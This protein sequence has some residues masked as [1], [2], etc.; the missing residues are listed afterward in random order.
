M[1]KLIIGL[2]TL[3]LS[4][5]AAMAYSGPRWAKSTLNVSIQKDEENPWKSVCIKNAFN[6]W[7]S[8]LNGLIKFQYNTGNRIVNKA[9]IVVTLV[10]GLAQ[11]AYYEIDDIA[12]NAYNNGAFAKG[13]Y[14]RVNIQI[15]TKEADGT[16][17]SKS[18]LRSIALQA[19]GNSL[20]VDCVADSGNVMSC[21]SQYTKLILTDVDKNALKAI[22]QGKM[23]SK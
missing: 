17:I 19:V 8:A 11:N 2:L 15:R 9:D 5:S 23:S 13:Y 18:K 21:D 14:L 4:V 16:D 1:K 10:D 20:G 22:Y 3:I 12:T 7:Q 6:D